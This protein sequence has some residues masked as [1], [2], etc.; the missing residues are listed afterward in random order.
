MREENISKY[1]TSLR[2]ITFNRSTNQYFLGSKTTNLCKKVTCHDNNNSAI[3]ISSVEFFRLL[4]LKEEQ[5]LYLYVRLQMNAN[6]SLLDLQI[7]NLLKKQSRRFWHS[8]IYYQGVWRRENS[9][10][11]V[12][13]VKTCGFHQ[14]HPR[15][16]AYECCLNWQLGNNMSDIVFLA[17]SVS[18]KSQKMLKIITHDLNCILIVKHKSTAMLVALSRCKRHF[19]LI[20][21]YSMLII[22]NKHKTQ[23]TAVVNGNFC[24]YLVINQTIVQVT[25][26]S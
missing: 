6:V 8:F 15:T 12:K 9:V 1:A 23:S 24:M 13:L 21:H 26:L 25:V 14:G 11:E 5:I 19:E 4:Q 16:Q 20:Q 18:P 22:S 2:I 7:G 3:P 17:C 10:K